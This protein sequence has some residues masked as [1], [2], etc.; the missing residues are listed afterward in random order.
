MRFYP[1][2]SKHRDGRGSTLPQIP[3]PSS[4]PTSHAGSNDLTID[5]DVLAA[6]SDRY[7]N[8]P[9]QERHNKEMKAIFSFLEGVLHFESTKRFTPQKALYHRFLEEAGVEGDDEFVPHRVGEGI[10]EAYHFRDEDTG[11]NYVK[12]LNK[13]MCTERKKHALGE[14]GDEVA[15]DS[16]EEEYQWCGEYF[17]DIREIEAGEGIAI[18]RQPC[19]FHRNLDF[20]G[21]D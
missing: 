3:P 17:E 15:L 2:N 20:S 16:D 10:C 6:Q 13:C 9:S 12:I 14:D 8:P 19:E 11:T 5:V 7:A 1:H 4:S 18:G 21:G